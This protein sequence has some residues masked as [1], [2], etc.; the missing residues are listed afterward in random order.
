MVDAAYARSDLF[1]QRRRLMDDWA[2]YLDAADGQV[3]TCHLADAPAARRLT[4]V[5]APAPACNDSEMEV[6]QDGDF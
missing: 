2:A 6:E 1:E 3:V 4:R 5:W